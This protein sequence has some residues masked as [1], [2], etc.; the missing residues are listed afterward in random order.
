MG[1]FE[2]KADK[3]TGTATHTKGN[4][5]EDS[6]H[7]HQKSE[8]EADTPAEDKEM[9][10]NPPLEGENGEIP[11]NIESL[12]EEI[13]AAKKDAAES[14]DRYL[15]M[16][17]DFDNYKKI[18]QRRMDDY[19]KFANTELLKDLLTVVD[20]LERA[21]DVRRENLSNVESCMIEGVEMTLNEILN[22]LKKYNVTQVDADRKPFDPNYH[23]AVM[24]EESD[25]LPDNT[26][27]KE[28]QKGYLLH[29]RLI[30]P[31]MVVVSKGRSTNQNK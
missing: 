4:N 16:C 14:H 1:K 18:V 8:N 21:L 13:D 2:K 11:P 27:K 9:G 5:R 6:M 3:T 24:Q 30:R 19:K 28:L 17:A 15:R 26:V 25:D 12:K 20:N 22:L 23:D 7:E 10:N 31:A 29:D